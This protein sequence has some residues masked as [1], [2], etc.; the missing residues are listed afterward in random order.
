MGTVNERTL[1]SELNA[2]GDTLAGLVGAL[3]VDLVPARSAPGL[4]QAFERLHRLSG[5]GMTLLARRVDD[6]KV[7]EQAGFRSSAHWAAAQSGTSPSHQQ[8]LL[9]TSKRL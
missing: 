4:W 7:W 9:S 2:C 1:T 5:A 6:S 8:G 3:D